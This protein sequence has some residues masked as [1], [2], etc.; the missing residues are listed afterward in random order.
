MKFYKYHGSGNDFILLDGFKNELELSLDFIRLLCHRRLGIGSDGLIIVKESEVADFNMEFY[1]PDGSSGMMCGNG[2]RCAIMLAATQGYVSDE[3][4]FMATDG[5]HKGILHDA[6][7]VSLTIPDIEEVKSVGECYFADSGAP[8]LVRILKEE[9]EDYNVHEVGRRLRN[10][11]EFK[12][13]GTNVNFIKR[14]DGNGN[15]RIRTYERGVEKE[16]LACGTGVTAAAVVVHHVSEKGDGD[17][18]LTMHTRTSPLQVN[19]H[20]KAPETYTNIWLKGPAEKVF[21][22]EFDMEVLRGRAGQNLP[23]IPD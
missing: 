21:E 22:G 4:T 20:N 10:S 3:M 18:V 2:A 12:P 19:F 15:Y 13:E 16:T 11:E 7:T 5:I 8:H 9:I 6:G 14:I 23:F 1:N 17:Y